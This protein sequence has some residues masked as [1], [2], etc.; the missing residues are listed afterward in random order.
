MYSNDKDSINQDLL[1]PEDRRGQLGASG[2][3]GRNQHNQVRYVVDEN[4][5]QLAEEHYEELNAWN[6]YQNYLPQLGRSPDLENARPV[7]RVS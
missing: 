4:D 6:I 3:E 1:R 5:S 2:E 7:I